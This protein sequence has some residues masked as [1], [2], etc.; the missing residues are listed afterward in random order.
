MSR[1][2]ECS[3]PIQTG[4]ETPCKAVFNSAGCLLIIDG[5]ELGAQ[6]PDYFYVDLEDNLISV[7]L[8]G[9]EHFVTPD[10]RDAFIA[11]VFG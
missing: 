4:F 3:V 11:M 9:S 10:D 8:E 2:F 1:T 7:S 5:M 6:I